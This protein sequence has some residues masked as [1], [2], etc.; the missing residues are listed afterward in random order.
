MRRPVPITPP[1]VRIALPSLFAGF[2]YMEY[3]PVVHLLGGSTE[4][5]EGHDASYLLNGV[6]EA[7]TVPQWR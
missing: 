2:V 3:A 5:M 4:A 1:S 7:V 6:V